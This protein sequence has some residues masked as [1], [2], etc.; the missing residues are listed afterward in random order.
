MIRQLV[1]P[2][3]ID[4]LH[5]RD[6]DFFEMMKS[7]A[8]T[9][10]PPE[11]DELVSTSLADIADTEVMNPAIS[12]FIQIIRV[13]GGIWKQRILDTE[14]KKGLVGVSTEH[15]RINEPSPSIFHSSCHECGEKF[16]EKRYIC[17]S[18]WTQI[19]GR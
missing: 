19:I 7:G 6:E 4:E 17:P 10:V 12:V 14:V 2:S 13:K 11:V 1:S 18:C 3:D 15:L 9:P 16:D 5:G 8:D